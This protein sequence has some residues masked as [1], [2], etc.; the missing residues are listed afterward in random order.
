[1][2]YEKL[3]IVITTHGNNGIYIEKCI[4]CFL[5][6]F[7]KSYII[8]FVNESKD[9]ITLAIKNKY[10]KVHYIYIENQI[11]NGGLT[12]TWNQ[13]ISL[14]LR[15]GCNT[16]IISNDDIYFGKSIYHIVNSA[17]RN[18]NGKKYFGP[19]TNNPGPHRA[20]KRNQYSNKPKRQV[21]RVCHFNKRKWNLNGFFMV[22]NKRALIRNKFNKYFYFNPKYP[23]GGNEKEWFHRFR[24]KGGRGI[25]VPKTFIFHHKFKSWRKN[26]IEKKMLQ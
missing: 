13:G 17:I 26:K 25:V 14:C 21:N 19:V 3:G 18:K 9:P 1:M 22:F 10:P 15:H 16:I 11:K 20:N 8:L 5:K 12:G 2:V 4:K 23:F 7:P 24:R 6:F